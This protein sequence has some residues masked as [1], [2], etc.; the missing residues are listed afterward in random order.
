MIIG[1]DEYKYEGYTNLG[2]AVADADRVEKFLLQRLRTPTDHIT[3]LRNAHATRTAIINAF[4][5]LI[6]DPR[7]SPGMPI[8]IY[9]AGHGAMAPKPKEWTD[10]LIPDNQIQMLCP[11]DMGDLDVNNKVVEGIPDRTVSEL[12]LKLATAKGNN[13]VRVTTLEYPQGE[14]HICLDTDPRLLLCRWHESTF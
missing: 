9:Y 11:T 4:E 6:H 10:W 5:S 12:L 7:I 8:V 13:I 14:T 3:S 2:A 1:I